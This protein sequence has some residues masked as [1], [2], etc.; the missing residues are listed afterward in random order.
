MFFSFF[1]K[2]NEA[3]NNQKEKQQRHIERSNGHGNS[4][5]FRKSVKRQQTDLLLRYKQHLLNLLIANDPE[6]NAKEELSSN[7]E[8]GD[9]ENDLEEFD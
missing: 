2:R 3:K 6:F 8:S 1:E 9:D 7:E 4:A 5:S